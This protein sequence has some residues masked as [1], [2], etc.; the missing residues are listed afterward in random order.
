MNEDLITN[1]G[2]ALAIK[3]YTGDIEAG[4]GLQ[5]D[6][7]VL[8]VTGKQDTL[9]FN[10]DSNNNI[11]K[12]D[13]HYIAPN[14]TVLWE[15][16]LTKGTSAAFSEPITN[17]D[18]YIFIGKDSNRGHGYFEERVLNTSETE[19]TFAISLTDGNFTAANAGYA[20][21]YFTSLTWNADYTGITCNH[22]YQKYFNPP[23]GSA[24]GSDSRGIILTKIIGKGRKES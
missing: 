19:K 15:G 18:R 5:F 9:A 16:E 13:N 14:E 24:A 22:L 23:S 8:S 4:D 17:Y 10:Y 7:N 2:L 21:W 11:V 12:I 6:G 20:G 3:E 1:E